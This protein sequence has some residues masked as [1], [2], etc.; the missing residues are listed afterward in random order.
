MDGQGWP[1]NMWG[2]FYPE[3][4]PQ[5]ENRVEMLSVIVTGFDPGSAVFLGNSNSRDT[6]MKGVGIIPFFCFVLLND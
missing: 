5:G 3:G 6:G 2:P 4:C 1:V